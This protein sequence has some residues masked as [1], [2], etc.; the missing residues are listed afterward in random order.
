M[1][2]H[3]TIDGTKL[4]LNK[5]QP[6]TDVS[7]RLYIQLPIHTNSFFCQEAVIQKHNQE[8]F[9]AV[10]SDLLWIIVS[11]IWRTLAA[12][13]HTNCRCSSFT[14]RTWSWIA[15]MW[16]KVRHM[17]EAKK[18]TRN[19][20][21]NNTEQPVRYTGVRIDERKENTLTPS[22]DI[23]T[24]ESQENM[25]IPWCDNMLSQHYWQV[26]AIATTYSGNLSLT[27]PAYKDHYFTK[28]P[29]QK[30]STQFD[31]ARGTSQGQLPCDAKQAVKVTIN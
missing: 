4:N 24:K 26:R 14:D 28:P 13:W 9:L 2:L 21:I 1:K 15:R 22:R 31:R 3:S 18:Y 16:W 5:I 25:L 6:E 17:T 19:W 12:S 7:L 30:F 27:S 10:H 8:N 23:L 29:W 11:H 20:K